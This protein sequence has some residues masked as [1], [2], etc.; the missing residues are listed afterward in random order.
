MYEFSTK[1]ISLLISRR[2]LYKVAYFEV[3]LFSMFIYLFLLSVLSVFYISTGTLLYIIY[4]LSESSSFLLVK[5]FTRSGWF[6]RSI[7]VKGR[8]WFVPIFDLERT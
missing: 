6:F 4:S 2:D 5:A 7:P 3:N 1:S 8:T